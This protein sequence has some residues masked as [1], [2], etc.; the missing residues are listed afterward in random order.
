MVQVL[1]QPGLSEEYDDHMSGTMCICL[2][3]NSSELGM[4]TTE[5]TDG[6]SPTIFILYKT[7]MFPADLC[8]CEKWAFAV[9]EEYDVQK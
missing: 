3:W 8:G 2:S 6:V 9:T 5:T 7:V 1:Q 4:S